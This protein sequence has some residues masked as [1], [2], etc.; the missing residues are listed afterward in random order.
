MRSRQSAAKKSPWAAFMFFNRPQQ[1]S[2]SALESNLPGYG[3]TFVIVIFLKEP[4]AQHFSNATTLLILPL[5][6]SMKSL[7]PS[8]ISDFYYV[9]TNS[10]V[11][12]LSTRIIHNVPAIFQPFHLAPFSAAACASP[13]THCTAHSSLQLHSIIFHNSHYLSRFTPLSLE[14]H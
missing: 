14:S 13:R 11:S 7:Q 8:F 4:S 9:N 5:L 2:L 3:D 1:I 6:L 10:I 12:T